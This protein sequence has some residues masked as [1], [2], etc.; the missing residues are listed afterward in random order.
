MA[1]PPCPWMNDTAETVVLR[2]TAALPIV[3]PLDSISL[4]NDR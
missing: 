1:T 4:N 3:E 2:L